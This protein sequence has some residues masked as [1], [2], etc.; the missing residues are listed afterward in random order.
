MPI[1]RRQFELARDKQIKGWMRKIHSFL[2]EHTNQA[3]SVDELKEELHPPLPRGPVE[4]TMVYLT[5][6][7]AIDLAIERLA[8]LDVI[9]QRK[10]SGRSYYLYRGPLALGNNHGGS[11]SRRT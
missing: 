2:A 11:P 10:V 3:Y 5:D 1:T 4:S 7:T 6:D 9:D 8:Q